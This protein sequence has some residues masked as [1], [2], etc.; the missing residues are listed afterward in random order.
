[1]AIVNHAKR[2]INAKIV[3]Y[4]HESAGKG[5]SLRYVFDR[6]KPTLRGELKIQPTTGSTLLFFDFSP[7]EQPV[8]GGYRIRFHIYTL[9][10]NVTNSAAWKMTL[11]GTDGL[12]F[13]ADASPGALPATQ[14]SLSQARDFMNA[15]GVGLH[16]IPMVLQLNKADQVGQVS[17]AELASNLGLADCSACLTTATTGEGVLEALSQLS[18]EI[19]LRIRERDDVP[20]ED[21]VVAGADSG[22]IQHDIDPDSELPASRKRVDECQPDEEPSSASQADTDMLRITVGEAG[23]SVE[24]GKVRIPLDVTQAGGIQRLVLTVAIG[25]G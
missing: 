12:V 3:Y 19:M 15:Y 21:G 10:G 20:Q 17:A 9:H 4:G 6:I 1:M 5:T 24:G 13:V 7:F 18:R 16:D 14:Q 22:D 25:P 2:E 8:F 23:V 11:K